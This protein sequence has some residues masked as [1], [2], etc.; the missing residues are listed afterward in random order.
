MPSQLHRIQVLL[1]PED[2][3]DVR[4]LASTSRRSYS[5]VCNALIK[6][7]LNDEKFQKMLEEAEELELR[8]PVVEDPRT[9]INLPMYL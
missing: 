5:F 8:K 6:H 2:N 1:S 4:T 7:A 3:A 9:R